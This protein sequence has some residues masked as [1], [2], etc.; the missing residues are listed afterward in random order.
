MRRGN[1]TR[2]EAMCLCACGL[3]VNPQRDKVFMRQRVRCLSP[4]DGLEISLRWGS[5]P[6]SR[7]SS[8]PLAGRVP[9]PLRGE[10]HAASECDCFFSRNKMPITA[11]KTHNFTGN[12]HPILWEINISITAEIFFSA[13]PDRKPISPF[14]YP[15]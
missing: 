2:I 14:N 12:R 3:S 13:R 4:S 1:S 11:K 10:I 8:Y 7:W 9:H 6:A 15:L 5:Q